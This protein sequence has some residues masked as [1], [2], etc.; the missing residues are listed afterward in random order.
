MSHVQGDLAQVKTDVRELRTDMAALKATV[1]DL[2]RKGFIVLTT[3]GG[4][5]L[6]AAVIAFADQ[7]RKL[8]GVH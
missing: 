5:G 6:F 2:P 8:L 4:M 1:A 3:I 7:I